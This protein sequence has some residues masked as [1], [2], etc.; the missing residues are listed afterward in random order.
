MPILGTLL[1]SSFAC[2]HSWPPNKPINKLNLKSKV[3]NFGGQDWNCMRSQ[4]AFPTLCRAWTSKWN[5]FQLISCLIP[6]AQALL[7]W[8]WVLP[9]IQEQSSIA[10]EIPEDDRISE[11]WRVQWIS[12]LCASWCPPFCSCRIWQ[13][14]PRRKAKGFVPR[15]I[16]SLRRKDGVSQDS[17]KTVAYS[18]IFTSPPHPKKNLYILKICHENSISY[19]VTVNSDLRAPQELL[20]CRYIEKLPTFADQAEE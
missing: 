15:R 14:F 17:E 12:C 16:L 1:R 5:L 7:P 2:F 11:F 18:Y 4:C 3:S 8:Q 9:P 19:K 13:S 20:L 10:T 6:L